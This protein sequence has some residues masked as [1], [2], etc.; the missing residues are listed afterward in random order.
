M[1]AT[2]SKSPAIMNRLETVCHACEEWN[3]MG[4]REPQPSW[5]TLGGQNDEQSSVHQEHSVAQALNPAAGISC[6]QPTIPRVLVSGLASHETAYSDSSESF[7][8]LVRSLQEGNAL[9]QARKAGTVKGKRRRRAGSLR[10]AFDP[11]GLLRYDRRLYIPPEASVRAELLKRHHDDELAGHFGIERTLELMSRKYYWP[12]LA[13]D[14]EEYVSSCDVC[15]R[16]KAPRHRPYGELQSLPR[17]SG[18][19]E[20][21]TMD[22]IMSLP[23]CKR[24]GSVYDAILVVVDH[25]TKMARYIPTS[26]T[27][28]AVQLAD[29][30][31]EEVVCRYG[32]PKGIVSDRGSIFTSS[33]WSEICYQTKIKRRLSTAFHPQ[34]DGQTE[35]QNQ[36]LEHYLRCYCNE[37]Q[38]NWANLLPLAEFAYINTK[39]VTLGCSPFYV[40]LGY[41]VFIH[42]DVENNV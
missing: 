5:N 3:G 41:N 33:Y 30:F 21:V 31:F 10:W 42:Y 32:T 4:P 34:T 14:V 12:E 6:L 9:V 20:E 7:L 13:K 26:K 23:S 39:Q 18:P 36:T 28:T 8:L 11:T 24:G 35:R 37:E 27:L 17:P 16:V 1:P 15:Q 40:M 2:I 22:M 25:Y 19:W 29:I 38:D